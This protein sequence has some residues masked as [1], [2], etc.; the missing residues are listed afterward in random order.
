MGAFRRTPGAQNLIYLCL[1][2]TLAS[3]QQTSF[4]IFV[5]PFLTAVTGLEFRSLG[6]RFR[7]LGFGFRVSALDSGCLL[8][9]TEGCFI[10]GACHVRFFLSLSLSLSRSLVCNTLVYF[11]LSLFSS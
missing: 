2:R 7:G 10:S 9:G 1:R 4:L 5:G 11:T 3:S 8:V 6:F